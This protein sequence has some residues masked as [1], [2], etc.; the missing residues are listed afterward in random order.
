MEIVASTTNGLLTSCVLVGRYLLWLAQMVLAPTFLLGGSTSSHAQIEIVFDSVPQALFGGGS[1]ALSLT[2]RNI[3]EQEVETPIQYRLYQTSS[4]TAMPMGQAKNWKVLQL[5]PHQTVLENLALELPSVRSESAFR[6]VWFAGQKQL[7]TTRLQVFSN[8]LLTSLGTLVGEN[9]L[10]VFDPE[11]R[12]ISALGKL[13]LKEIKDADELSSCPCTLFIVTPVVPHH[14]MQ[15][16]KSA[17]KSKAETGAGIVWLQPDEGGPRSEL[18]TYTVPEGKGRVVVSP[19]TPIK[20]LSQSP[21][22]Q[23]A[24]IRLCEIATGCSKLELPSEP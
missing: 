2:L 10:G 20:S 14:A 21:R 13:R 3:G 8:D 17:I 24:L 18:G 12:L 11:G 19:F 15:A 4:S 7:G 5:K 23:L 1:R 16:M 22:A 6:V 9:G